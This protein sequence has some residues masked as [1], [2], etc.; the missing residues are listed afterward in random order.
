MMA[1]LA[2]LALSAPAHADDGGGGA[3]YSGSTGT[4]HIHAT[5]P[6]QTS[7][8]PMPFGGGHGRGGGSLSS[9]TTVHRVYVRPSPPS[10]QSVLATVCPGVYGLVVCPSAPA[11]PGVLGQVQRVAVPD[12]GR[13]ALRAVG[14]LRLVLAQPR[15]AP[16]YPDRTVV[17]VEVWMWVPESQ[18]K[19]L[20]ASVSAGPTT[21]AVRA[22]PSYVVW[23]T[24]EQPHAVVGVRTESEV[25]RCVGRSGATQAW[26]RAMTDEAQTPCGHTYRTTS[27]RQPGGVFH[28]RAALMYQ[29]DWTCTGSCTVGGGDLGELSGPQAQARLA[30]V[31]RQTVVVG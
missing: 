10:V 27:N 9:P 23:H 14:E 18:W 6:G 31:E 5:S 13:L 20:T 24:G 22:R 17:G 21:V 1:V 12:P 29:V 11:A 28:L 3:N 26:R 16:A 19:T 30:S 7:P 2:G 15:T 4:I 8:A 25:E